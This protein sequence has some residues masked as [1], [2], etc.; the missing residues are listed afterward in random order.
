MIACYIII[1][2][3]LG[4][5]IWYIMAKSKKYDLKELF[6]KIA[7]SFLFMV[8]AIVASFSSGKFTL[9]NV[10][11]II[12][13]LLGLLGDVFLDLKYVDR[14]RENGYTYAGF[15]VFGIGH[16]MYMTALTLNYH[17][18]SPLYIIFAI[19]LALALAVL[20]ILLEKPLKLKYGKM[21]L[22]SFLY[23]ICLFGT[24]SFSFLLAIENGFQ[25]TSLN[26]FLIGAALFVISDLV[27]S[28]TF[29]GEGK[30][31]PIDFILNYST[32]YCD[33]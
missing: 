27:L 4:L 8:V 7:I 32:Y 21:K 13:L 23:A 20:P 14:E 24:L 29:F 9:F 3:A 18:G 12:G 19:L 15:I 16:F 5:T 28:G 30:E 33:F 17:N 6:L 2:V 26:M 31:R 1:G 10:F 11:V 25:I 22:I